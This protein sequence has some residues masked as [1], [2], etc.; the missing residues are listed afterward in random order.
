METWMII[1]GA[2]V[3]VAAGAPFLIKA[4]TRRDPEAL[5]RERA[6]QRE[7]LERVTALLSGLSRT[8]RDGGTVAIGVGS[9]IHDEM[10]KLRREIRR[11][12]TFSTASE[13]D[14]EIGF[15]L[16]RSGV[17]QMAPDALDTR[18]E[19]ATQA[20]RSALST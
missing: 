11:V 2:S 18:I 4:I 1:A 5:A 14:R 13:F 19:R 7:V 6:E 12:F 20:L 17:L 8:V 10:A 9:P 15:E 3:V 16:N